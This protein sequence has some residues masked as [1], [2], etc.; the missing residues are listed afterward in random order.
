M[1]V[2]T[3]AML[4]LAA[5]CLLC[6]SVCVPAQVGQPGIHAA[7]AESSALRARIEAS[8]KLPYRGVPLAAQPPTVGWQAGP[9]SGVAVAQDGTLYEI[10]RGDKAEPIVVLDRSGKVL[11]SWGNGDFVL[12]HTIRLDAAGNVWAV[13]AAASVAIEYS[14]LGKRLMTITVGG[15]PENGSAFNGATDIAFAP[16][17]HIFITDGY[18]NARVLEYTADGRGVREWGKAG[19]GPG[20]FELPHAIQI[21][22]QGMIYIADRENGR[23]EVF[24]PAGHYRSEI[25]NLGRVY[26]IKLAGEVIWATSSP[27]DE[28]PG[29]PGWVL[30]LDRASGRLLGHIDIAES[31]GGHAIDVTAEGEP[32]ITFGDKLLVF[33]PQ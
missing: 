32:V 28:P 6:S 14:P 29:S 3:R 13:D 27:L 23:I 16:N 24:D 30:K 15:Q 7:P 10:Q 9:V 1:S 12:P 17:G 11:R 5:Y 8:P 26:S 18:G 33:E 31:G 25:A 2:A 22:P 21:D 19:E 4:I 20:E